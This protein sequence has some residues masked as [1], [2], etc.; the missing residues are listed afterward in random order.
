MKYFTAFASCLCIGEVLASSVPAI[1]NGIKPKNKLRS[2]LSQ[3]NALQRREESE[4]CSVVTPKMFII[5]M[6]DSEADVWYADTELNLYANNI[7]VPGFSPL[8]PEAHCTASGEICQLT[9]GEG[10][11]FDHRDLH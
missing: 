8:F 5:S 6:F 2:T 7:T 1:R 11:Q 10:G 3:R 4:A 9:T